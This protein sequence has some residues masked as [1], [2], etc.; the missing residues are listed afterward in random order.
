MNERDLDIMMV[1]VEGFFEKLLEEYYNNWVG[2][3][4]GD[5][6]GERGRQPAEVGGPVG[7][8]N[9]FDIRR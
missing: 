7:S 8:I 9:Q 5:L 2:D 3:R 1:E 6:Y 4:D